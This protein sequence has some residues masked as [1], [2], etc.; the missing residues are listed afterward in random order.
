MA[1]IGIGSQSYI[2]YGLQS[3]FGTVQ[4]SL[5]T[6][7]FIRTGSIFSLRQANQ[8]RTTTSAIMP[9]ASQLWQTLALV[10]FDATW[11]YVFNDTALLPLFTAAFGRRLKTGGGAP[12]TYNYT[13]WN[14]PVDGGTDGTPSGTV[15][16][17][18]LTV[19]EIVSDGVSTF[20]PRVVQD[21]CINRFVLTMNANEQLRFQMTGTGQK[22]AA[23]TAPG[24]TDISGTTAS[25]IHANSTAN[26][27]L[28]IGTANP[29]TTQ[30]MAKSVVFTLENN[31]RYE[32]FL[33]ATAG[34]DLKLPTRA[35][36][37][38]AQFAVTADFEDVATGFDAVQ[39]YT[40][41]IA[42]TKNNFRI[43][44]YET[45]NSSLELLAT[46]STGINVLDDLKPVYQGE[47]VVGFTF[48][49]NVFP[50]NIG[51]TPATGDELI[52][53]QTTG[54]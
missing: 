2:A 9:K 24:F 27:G 25:Y 31:L 10:D 32:P 37:P 47:G 7:A 36:W 17:H 5:I 52:V 20:S 30:F 43:E 8:P 22:H 23:S 40:D 11:E 16:N 50:N 19:R 46:S 21:I 6:S 38:S 33:G 44:Y 3:A 48:N 4:T 45:A 49:L 34:Q 42:N 15:Y 29:P 53:R 41:F 28:F 18:A 14:P 39:A 12:F 13:L 26:S 35:G 51:L 1:G 54:T